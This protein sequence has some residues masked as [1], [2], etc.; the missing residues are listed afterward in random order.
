M[1]EFASIGV[2]KRADSCTMNQ[3]A[4]INQARV[5]MRADSAHRCEHSTNETH[6]GINK[7]ARC[8]MC[9]AGVVLY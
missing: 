3:Q 8:M 6:Q 1:L 5:P 2:H 7:N 9:E 4:S